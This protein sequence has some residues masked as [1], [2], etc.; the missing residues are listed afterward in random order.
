LKKIAIVGPVPLAGIG[1]A[2]QYYVITELLSKTNN[3]TDATLICPNF[4][5]AAYVLNGLKLNAN[6]LGVYL[7]K[8]QLLSYFLQSIMPPK[9]GKLTHW[10]S[11]IGKIDKFGALTAPMYRAILAFDGGL[12]GGH[13]VGANVSYYVTQYETLQTIVRGPVV[14]WPFTVSNLA[15]KAPLHDIE[16]LKNSLAKFDTIFVRG[17]IFSRSFTQQFRHKQIKNPNCL[18]QRF[19]S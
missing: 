15:L 12:I 4:Q 8:P 5:E 1:A 18:G 3:D 2:L 9:A 10:I 13:T 14:T 6:T 11:K 7:S 16:R 19:W 17:N